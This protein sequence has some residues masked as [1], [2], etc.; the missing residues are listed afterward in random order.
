MSTPNENQLGSTDP[1]ID[2]ALDAAIGGLQPETPPQPDPK[3]EFI[4][5]NVLMEKSP[6]EPVEPGFKAEYPAHLFRQSDSEIAESISG[7]KNT[8]PSIGQEGRTWLKA[9]KGAQ[10]MRVG[11]KLQEANLASGEWKQYVEVGGYR[12]Y[13]R[14][15]ISGA[16]D[17]EISGIRAVNHLRHVMHMGEDRETPLYASGI[18]ITLRAVPDS[19]LSNLET[20]VLSEK[21]EI[22]RLTGGAGL[23]A[24]GIYLVDHVA[25]MIINNMVKTNVE[26]TS[27]DQLLDL[28]LVTDL[29]NL[30]LNQAN[31]IFPK[32]YPIEVPCTKD[33]EKCQHVESFNLLLRYMVDHR[34]DKLT[35][36]QRVHMSN[37]DRKITIKDVEKYQEEGPVKI[38]KTVSVRGGKVRIDF[39]TPTLRQYIQD[40]RA[41]I[42]GITNMVDT[43]LS[44]HLDERQRQFTVE[45]Q[46]R[47]TT[48]RQYGHFIKSVTTVA[49]DGSESTTTDRETLLT[50]LNDLS[51][52]DAA[53]TAIVAG[54]REHIEAA[55]VSVVGVPKTPCPKCQADIELTD[56]EKKHPKIIPV[57]ALNLFFTLLSLKLAKRQSTKL[58]DI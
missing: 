50:M 14:E 36:Y 13:A 12:S 53:L 5:S 55:T 37:P 44:E 7:F 17:R 57:D 46:A 29:Q 26:L 21:E 24:T 4:N 34:Q 10:K 8:D 33:Y 56:E 15:V 58:Q 28:I 47:L 32:G 18:H 16:M 19:D 25:A 48:L 38:S 6:L 9:V 31:T 22:G 39:R 23:S 30:S 27:P 3:A 40:G 54:V 51:S 42:D 2:T 1:N 49:N 11:K 43:I 41:W 52:D 35:E 45:D 20:L